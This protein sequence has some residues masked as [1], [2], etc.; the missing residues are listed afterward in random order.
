MLYNKNLFFIG[1]LLL[2]LFVN[3]TEAQQVVTDGLLVY[4]TFNE[5]DIDGEEVMDV[6]GENHG[7]IIGNAVI[8]EGKYGTALEFDGAAAYVEV[9]HTDDMEVMW[10]THT[11]E[12]W[13]YQIESRSSRILDKITA[14]TA[15][16]PH[17]DT[18]P[19]TTL[20]TCAGTVFLPELIIPWKNGLM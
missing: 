4:L 11:M 19:G 7:I 16:G 18:H 3:L 13:I 14:G 6:F 10:E 20:R 5:S 2:V 12:A 17:L 8:V 15:D 1:F 9:P